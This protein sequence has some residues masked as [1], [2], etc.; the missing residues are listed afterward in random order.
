M[1][2]ILVGGS[3]VLFEISTDVAY[4]SFPAIRIEPTLLNGSASAEARAA[5]P[6]RRAVAVTKGM[7]RRRDTA[8]SK[9]VGSA[10][11]IASSTSSRT[12]VVESSEPPSR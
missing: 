4:R 11:T 7:N 6:T 3:K 8:L 10:L 12:E 9:L 1:K 2:A 5:P